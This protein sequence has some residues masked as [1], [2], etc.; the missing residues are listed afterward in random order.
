MTTLQIKVTAEDIEQGMP[1]VAESCPIA[2][3]AERG[4][5]GCNPDV[6]ETSIELEVD[7]TR[8]I[9]RL[10]QSAERFVNAIDGNLFQKHIDPITFELTEDMEVIEDDDDDGRCSYDN[11]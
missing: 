7:G 9:F 4:Y 6:R 1:G 10:P 3:A 8:R 11:T 5:P 2:L